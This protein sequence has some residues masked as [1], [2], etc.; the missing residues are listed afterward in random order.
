MLQRIVTDAHQFERARMSGSTMV[1]VFWVLFL[2]VSF[3]ARRI[4]RNVQAQVSHLDGQGLLVGGGRALVVVGSCG[5]ENPRELKLFEVSDEVIETEVVDLD[6]EVV[7]DV[8]EGVEVC[9][10]EVQLEG[11][12]VRVSAVEDDAVNVEQRRP[13]DG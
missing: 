11:A 13:D 9:R 12:R 5:A 10:Q 8:D 3:D 7:G 2:S 4:A 6:A 1:I